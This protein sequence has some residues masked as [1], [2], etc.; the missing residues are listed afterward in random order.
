MT[1]SSESNPSSP[2]RPNRLSRSDRAE[3]AAGLALF[4]VVGVSLSGLGHGIRSWAY[5]TALTYLLAGIGAILIVR[6]LIVV[7]RRTSTDTAEAADDGATADAPK[8]RVAT[9]V[10]VVTGIAVLYAVVT[11]MLGFW[12]TSFLAMGGLAVFLSDRKDVRR[13]L[14]TLVTVA[15]VCVAGYLLFLQVFYVPVPLGPFEL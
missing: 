12:L 8:S 9:D 7:W 4:A 11:P 13:I 1:T 15:A 6:R 14:L 5:P 10:A 3:L 2:K